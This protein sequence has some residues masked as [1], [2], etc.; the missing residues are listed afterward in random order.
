MNQVMFALLQKKIAEIKG[1]ST[2]EVIKQTSL[3][4]KL[5]FNIGGNL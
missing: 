5:L 4:A 1:I 2:E 3:N